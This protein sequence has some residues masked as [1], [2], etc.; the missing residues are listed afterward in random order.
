MRFQRAFTACCC[1]FEEI[2]KVD[3]NQRNYFENANACNKC[4]LKTRVALGLN[5]TYNLDSYLDV[6]EF[7][8]DT[9][10][11]FIVDQIFK[12]LYIVTLN[13]LTL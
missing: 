10:D 8:P 7:N 1:D 9:F 2:T 13:L 12:N 11:H 6:G 3:S 5:L 4:M